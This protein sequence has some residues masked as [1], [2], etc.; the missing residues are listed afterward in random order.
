VDVAADTLLLEREREVS[1]LEGAVSGVAGQ[2]LFVEGP[3]GVG[4]TRLVAGARS[5]ARGAGVTVLEARGAE[6]EREFA[7]GVAR[8]LLEPTILAAGDD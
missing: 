7:F 3:P 4:K 8:Q 6:L 2:L 1:V 5:A